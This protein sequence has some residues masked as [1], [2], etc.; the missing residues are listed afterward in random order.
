MSYRG[1]KAEKILLEYVK[2]NFDDQAE[3]KGGIILAMKE[4][5]L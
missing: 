3:S 4:P 1:E 2:N 5:L